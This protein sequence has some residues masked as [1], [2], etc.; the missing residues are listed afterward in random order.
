MNRYTG[1]GDFRLCHAALK[2]LGEVKSENVQRVGGVGASWQARNPYSRCRE[3]PSAAAMPLTWRFSTIELTPKL[4]LLACGWIR[5]NTEKFW[6]APKWST[7]AA[8]TSIAAHLPSKDHALP[9]GV[10]P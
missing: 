10:E 2:R 3:N 4:L 7:G 9:L 8:A 1:P 5:A 6:P